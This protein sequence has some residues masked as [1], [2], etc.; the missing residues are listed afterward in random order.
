MAL[1]SDKDASPV[2]L[3]AHT[4]SP[5]RTVFTEPGNTD[6]WISTDLT[7]DIRR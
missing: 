3:R 1:T 6:G 4:T 5:N 7:V 2:G